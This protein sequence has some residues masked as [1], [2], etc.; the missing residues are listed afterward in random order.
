MGVR[1]GVKLASA[2]R[3]DSPAAV[4]GMSGTQSAPDG[5]LLQRIHQLLT[6]ISPHP[7]ALHYTSLKARLMLHSSSA[8]F[9]S[10]TVI[11]PSWS[12]SSSAAGAPEENWAA[13]VSGWARPGQGER[14]RQPPF[15]CA[16]LATVLVLTA[17]KTLTDPTRMYHSLTE[18]VVDVLGAQHL[19][20]VQRRRNELLHAHLQAWRRSK[21][22]VGQ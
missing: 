16:H 9:S 20:L 10:F 5:A 6:V 21:R 17:T 15:W 7:P 8:S 22:D 11:S 14:C 12:R 1:S 13:M 3:R 18:D 2:L 4:G 19:A